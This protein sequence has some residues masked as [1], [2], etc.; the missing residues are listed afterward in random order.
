[1]KI[2]DVQAYVVRPRYPANAGAFEGDWTF[3]RI[4]TDEGIHGW[5]EASNS[6]GGGCFLSARTIEMLRQG[7]LGQDPFQS[8]KLWQQNYRRYTYLGARGLPTV[9]LSGVD[10][11]LWDIKG[12]ALGR[13]V[14]DLL[15]GKLRDSIRLYA[16]G[17]FFGC[18]TPEQYGAAAKATVE[19]G[20]Q[21]L[22]LDPFLE[23]QPFHT[24]YLSGQI[25]AEGE[26]LGCAI[27]Q[28]VREAVG[29]K[30]EILIDAH[31]HYN[32]PTA[33][34]LANRLYDESQIAWFEEPVPP[35]S[36]DALRTV[37]EHVTPS[38][39]VGE[40]LFTRFDVLPILQQGLADY[41]MPDV[42]W[43]GGITELRKISSLAEAYY[44]PMSPHNAMGPLQIVGRFPRHDEHAQ[45]L[46]AGAQHLLHRS[47]QPVDDRAH[48]LPWR[49]VQPER[50]T[51]PGC[52]FRHGG[53][54]LPPAS[55]VEVRPLEKLPTKSTKEKRYPRRG[56]K[57]RR[58]A[59][60]GL[61]KAQEDPDPPGSAGVP[62]ASYPCKRA[63]ASP[64]RPT[65]PA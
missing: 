47:L 19:A 54:K 42:L 44:I 39:C 52:G 65:Q 29:D 63:P 8:E 16:N 51:R 53:F 33:I 59:T 12:K 45:L 17:W 1:M 24:G 10:I 27:V 56:T 38:I 37:R 11:A 55:G 49:G 57:N 43:T 36:I 5:G 62:P 32:V 30:V 31:G 13:P 23:M 4:D 40:R 18:S 14:Y 58:R 9:A 7:L 2:T 35:E 46:P 22:K 41:L 15:G 34:R 48:E 25:S 3:V 61:E 50:K 20:H 6:P 28:A 60:K 26:D 21:A 64:S